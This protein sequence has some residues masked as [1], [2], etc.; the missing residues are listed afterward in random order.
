[1]DKK[2]ENGNLYFDSLPDHI[3]HELMLISE[4]ISDTLD[5][6]ADNLPISIFLCA[7][8]N[9]YFS[10]LFYDVFL[11]NANEMEK[12]AENLVR[13]HKENI[14]AVIRASREIE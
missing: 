4:Q 1:M 11:G 10:Y 14:Q 2:D 5:P 6:I 13:I 9:Y 7:L 8:N 3:Q 12:D